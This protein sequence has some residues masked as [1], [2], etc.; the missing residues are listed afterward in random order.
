MKK[1][2]LAIFCALFLFIGKNVAQTIEGKWYGNLNVQGTALPLVFSFTKTDTTYS[3][4]LASPK[5]GPGEMKL[6]SVNFI[7]ANLTATLNSPNIEYTGTLN[8]DNII[9]G[10]F[11]QGGMSLPL[12]LSRQAIEIKKVNHPQEPKEP[13]NYYTEDVFFKNT[14]ANIELA[15]TLSLPTKQGKYPVVVLVSGS[16]PQNRNEELLGHKPFLVIADFLTKNGIGVLRYDDRGI[17]KSAGSFVTAT[18]NDF[19]DD[20][21]AAVKYLSTRKEVSKIGIIGHSEGGL[22]A[23]MVAVQNKLVNFIVLLAGTGVKGDVLL[24]EQIALVT[25]ASGVS[26]ADIA[27]SK[28]INN[29]M[30]AILTKSK[31]TEEAK[32]NLTKY[33][34][35]EIKN[36]PA[37]D[38]PAGVSDD[39]LLES[40][41]RQMATPWMINFLKYDPAPNLK[42][43]KCA[44]L[45]LNGDKDLQVPS[46]MNLPAIKKAITSNGNKNVTT[47]EFKNLNH[48]FQET[49]TGNPA[50]YETIEQTFSPLVLEE[51]LA[52]IK[53]KTK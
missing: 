20:A 22:I 45:A 1:N 8:K 32:I 39:E 3:G 26:D 33:L 27:T 37:A 48:L 25:K 23:P 17:A 6:T 49:T 46:T 41:V 19:A 9:E 34:G 38:K 12:N 24:A 51:I 18:T 31:T 15:G 10:T 14:K 11:K 47:K 13:F 7:N 30:F 53:L 16:G 4:T 21:N 44:V 42:K 43:V 28:K 2:L 36:M 5:Q 29:G 50:E 40:L 35:A 52:W